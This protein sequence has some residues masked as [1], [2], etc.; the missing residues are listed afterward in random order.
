MIGRLIGFLVWLVLYAYV[1][2][3]RKPSFT[4][5]NPDGSP[6]LQRWPIQTREPWPDPEGRTG[7]EGWYLHKF[8]SSDDARSLHNH[9]SIYSVAWILRGGYVET[10]KQVDMKHN[11]WSTGM[12]RYDCQPGKMNVITS[13]T[14]HRVTLYR[15]HE[16]P[17]GVFGGERV[18]WSLFYMGPRSERGWGFLQ[19][20]GRVRRA[21][22]N[23]GNTGKQV[24]REGF[25]E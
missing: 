11:P 22:H 6:Y 23:D 18:S 3:T 7:G 2:I 15:E 1:R 24:E 9:P 14:F 17:A 12:L 5:K 16:T 4:F 13:N 21:I 10:R 8:L 19:D 20:D 25:I